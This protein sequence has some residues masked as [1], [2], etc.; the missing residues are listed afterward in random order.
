MLLTALMLV[1]ILPAA[2]L[3]EGTT[4]DTD[5]VITGRFTGHP[6]RV[7]RNKLTREILAKEKED[8][9]LEEFEEMMNGTLRKA[10]VDGDAD[11]GSLM[12][13]QSAG[14]VKKE[15]T[16]AEIISDIISIIARM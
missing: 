3:A 4:T 16:A 14:L 7:L 13:G 12:A 9:S 6:V 10:V 2:V 1:S 5:T 15:E 8:I 11:Y